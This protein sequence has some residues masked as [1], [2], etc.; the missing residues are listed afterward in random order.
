M[1]N[2]S[3]YYVENINTKAKTERTINKYKA[4]KLFENAKTFCNCR[5]ICQDEFGKTIIGRN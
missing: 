4:Y 1:K 3:F 5:L 2:Y